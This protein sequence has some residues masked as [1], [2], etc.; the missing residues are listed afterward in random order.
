MINITTSNVTAP[1]TGWQDT[2]P[3]VEEK[4][5]IWTRSHIEWDDGASS[6][7]VP[8]LSTLAKGL[9]DAIASIKI[10]TNNIESKVSKT[11]Y[12]GTTISSLI[13]QDANTIL[14]KASKIDLVGQVTFKSFDKDVQNKLSN[15]TENSSNALDKANEANDN[16]SSALDKVTELENKANN[17]DFDGRGVESTKIEYKVTDDGITTPSNEG[18]STT[19]PVVSEDDYL[20]TRTTITYTS[21]DPSVIYSV[22]HMAVNGDSIIVKSIVVTYGTSKNPNIKPTNFSTDIPVASLENTYGVKLLHLFRWEIRR[23]LLLCFARQ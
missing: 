21:G 16:S 20:W 10:N 11:D 14:I 6:N 8:I 19:F 9:S 18:W 22:S 4:T 23:N 13:N 7:T 1:T 5:Y 15:A 12:T 17:G 3:T 2:C